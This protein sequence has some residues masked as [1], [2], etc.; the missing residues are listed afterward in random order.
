MPFL[1]KVIVGIISI[2]LLLTLSYVGKKNA[3]TM[4]EFCYGVGVWLTVMG[5]LVTFGD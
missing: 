3:D 2:I 1:T 5:L 4:G